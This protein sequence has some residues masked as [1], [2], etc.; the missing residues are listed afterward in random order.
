MRAPGRTHRPGA[1]ISILLNQAAGSSLATFVSPLTKRLTGGWGGLHCCSDFPLKVC[2]VYRRCELQPRDRA[3]LD[4]SPAWA[5]A[6]GEF[7]RTRLSPA[8]FHFVL[9]QVLIFV[10]LCRREVHQLTLF[11]RSRLCPAQDR[12]LDQ[13]SRPP[14]PISG[15]REMLGIHVSKPPQSRPGLGSLQLTPRTGS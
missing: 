10:F 5:P 12:I 6:P 9:L 15:E 4:P 2:T 8:V 3:H 11:T 7:T 13:T 1:P 14:L